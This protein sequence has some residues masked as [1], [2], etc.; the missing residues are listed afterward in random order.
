MNETYMRKF[1]IFK[2]RIK[3]VRKIIHFHDTCACTE[4][5]NVE[6][7]LYWMIRQMALAVG[8]CVRRI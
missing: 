6:L 7:G 5:H 3:S 2:K 1:P 8:F 4:D